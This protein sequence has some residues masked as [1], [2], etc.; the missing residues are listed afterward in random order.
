MDIDRYAPAQK[1]I[2]MKFRSSA[3]QVWTRMQGLNAL[4]MIWLK[5]RIVSVSSI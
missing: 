3:Y 5:R 1:T 4:R 2:S